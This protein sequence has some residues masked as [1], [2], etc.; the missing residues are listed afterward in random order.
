MLS[1]SINGHELN[2]ETDPSVF[3]PGHI[4]PGTLAMLSYVELT[5]DTKLLDLG[6]GCGTVGLWAATSIPSAQITMVDIDSTA[7]SLASS[8]MHSNDFPDAHIY[9]SDGLSAVSDTDY[10][11]ILSNPPYHTD[12]AVAKHF[13]EDGFRHLRVGGRMIMVTKRRT[14]YENKL[15]SVFGGVRVYEKDDYFVFISEKRAAKPGHQS[16]T[17]VQGSKAAD[18]G[19]HTRTQAVSHTTAVDSSAHLSKKLARKMASRK[20]H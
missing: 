17:P 13:I 7:V 16:S 1:W 3:S 6:C 12:F 11:L 2:I 19:V 9:T 4:D 8:N 14:W 20:K 10:D 5:P 15:T 18:D